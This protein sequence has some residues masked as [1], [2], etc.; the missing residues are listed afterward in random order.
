MPCLARAK[1]AFFFFVEEYYYREDMKAV[2]RDF[3]DKI[4]FM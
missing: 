2:Y 3:Y 4:V 1:G